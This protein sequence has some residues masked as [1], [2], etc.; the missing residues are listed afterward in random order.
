MGDL[1][2]FFRFGAGFGIAALFEEQ[3]SQA[4]SGVADSDRISRLQR[5]VQL[6]PGLPLAGDGAFF[7]SSSW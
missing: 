3:V 5:A 2:G 7:L 4:A 1:E 6:F